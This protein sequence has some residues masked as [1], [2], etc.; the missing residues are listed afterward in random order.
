MDE[1]NG[2]RSF[3]DAGSHPLYRAMP[4]IA[5]RK[6]SGKICFEQIRIPAER[7]SLRPL[8][9]LYQIR[10]GQDESMLVSLNDVSEPVGSRR[11][12]D[13]NK[14]RTRRHAFGLVTVRTKKGDFLKMRFAVRFRDTG[15]CPYLN[16][17]TFLDL[18]NEV[19]RHGAGERLASNH[20]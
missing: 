4:H 3:T 20:D 6:Q 8:A 17:G 13:K 5:H 16:I 15:V 10:A 9:I 19:L 7:P 11:S 12:S 14:H 18:V 1:L 2:D